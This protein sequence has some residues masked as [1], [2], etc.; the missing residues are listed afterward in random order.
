MWVDDALL[1]L[2]PVESLLFLLLFSPTFNHPYLLPF[3]LSPL[4]FQVPR[5][6]S[7]G[8]RVR[9][10]PHS[11]DPPSWNW[12]VLIEAERRPPLAPLQGLSLR[13]PLVPAL[14]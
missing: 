6:R 2:H 1:T 11:S 13:L 12:M 7:W 14:F 5:A 4:I 8:S 9:E 10:K 3:L